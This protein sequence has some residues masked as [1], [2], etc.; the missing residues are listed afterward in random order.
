MTT[1]TPAQ[2]LQKLLT[3]GIQ[4]LQE[5]NIST[6]KT[7]VKHILSHMLEISNDDFWRVYNGLKPSNTEPTKIS[8]IKNQ[9]FEKKFLQLLQQRRLKMPLAK[10]IAEQEF[11]SLNFKISNNVLDPRP[12]TEILVAEACKY[13]KSKIAKIKTQQQSQLSPTYKI[14]ILELGVG[15][16]CNIITIA[17]YYNDIYY[18]KINNFL[19]VEFIGSD[20]CPK[21]L[22]IAKEN[23]KTHH[24]TNI[25]FIQSDWFEE[26]DIQHNTLD[27]VISNPPYIKSKDVASLDSEVL[28]YDPHLALDG[29][30]DGLECYRKIFSQLSIFLSQKGIAIFEIGYG[31][32]KHIQKIA[33]EYD[34]T[35]I[36]IKQ[37]E[38]QIDRIVTFAKQ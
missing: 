20:I 17:K 1:L 8:A 7:D 24:A 25:N 31:Q 36:D 26:I 14:K 21:A 30:Q 29:G 6:A 18:K 13:L 27:L 15:S 10:I 12:C 19:D 35:T 38:L 2:Q 37:D 11:C 28:L 5:G 34:F 22:E 3:Q 9:D 23:A 4:F 32:L 33:L 16:G